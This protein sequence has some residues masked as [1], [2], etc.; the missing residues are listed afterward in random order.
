M[1]KE[2]LE[3]MKVIAVAAF[4]A[5]IISFVVATSFWWGTYFSIKMVLDLIVQAFS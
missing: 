4:A 3:V 2:F 1:V 5:G